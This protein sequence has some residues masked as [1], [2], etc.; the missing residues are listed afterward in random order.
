MEYASVYTVYQAVKWL[1]DKNNAGI[2]S[3]AE[4]NT[5]VLDQIQRKV[6]SDIFGKINKLPFK[7]MAGRSNMTLEAA[8]ISQLRD[9]ILPLEKHQTLSGGGATYA[10]PSDYYLKQPDPVL[11]NGGIVADIVPVREILM[12]MR[13]HSGAPTKTNPMCAI[14]SG[15]LI[16]YPASMTVTSVK[17]LYWKVPQGR[18]LAGAATAQVPTYGSTTSVDG[19]ESYNP[20]TTTNFELTKAAEPL[21]IDEFCLQAGINI[22]EQEMIQYAMQAMAKNNQQ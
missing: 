4:M 1:A 14:E 12:M 7:K 19:V 3:I 16:V 2:I 6:V 9:M 21:L 15:N 20:A 8:E 18:T 13:T 5:G 10:M 17:L 22:R 11:I